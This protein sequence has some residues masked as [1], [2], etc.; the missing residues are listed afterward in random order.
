MDQLYLWVKDPPPQEVIRQELLSAICHD[1]RIKTHAF[2]YVQA[3]IAKSC[4]VFWQWIS[5]RL[6]TSTRLMRFYVTEPYGR[7]P[8]HID[9]A[10]ITVP[11]GLNFPVL[12]CGGT[13]MTWYDVAAD[14][15]ERW[16]DHNEHGY[17]SSYRL[18]T[19][20]EER[21]RVLARLEIT[22]PC[23]VRNDIM[24]SVENPNDSWRIMLSIRFPLD[25]VLY[26]SISEVID[27]AVTD[28]RPDS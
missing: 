17:M 8:P 3:Y 20:A 24:H 18:R 9:G 28:R 7:L 14:D 6:K 23:F 26:R 10:P 21:S 25:A 12:N 22:S 16:R 19:A 11:F 1:Y 13:T 15:V 27:C 4:P 5:T 2:T